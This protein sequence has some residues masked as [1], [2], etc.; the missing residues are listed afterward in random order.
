MNLK[1]AALCTAFALALSSP[2]FGQQ[3]GGDFG[4]WREGV[5]AEAAA[6]GVGQRG[7]SA[8][9]RAEL[10]Q[11]VIN[12]DRGQRVFTQTFAEFAGRMIN[13]YRLTHGKRNLERYRQT[14]ARAE[15]EFG[16]P[17]PVISS[18]WALETDFGAVQGDFSTLDALTTLA[19]DCRRPELFRPEL[20]ALLRLIDQGTVSADVTGAWAGEIGQL[21]MLPSDYLR[22][23][24][25]GDGD[26]RVDLKGSAPDAILT[27][28]NKLRALGWKPGQPWMDEVEVPEN[29]PWDQTGRVSKLPRAQWAAW[30]VRLRG[31]SALPADE[32]PAALVLPMGYK[33]PA[34]L[35]YDNYDTYL[36]WNKSLVYTLT[37]AQL[38]RRLDGAPPFRRGNPDPG[39]SPEQ[40][41]QLQRKL[42]EMGY[43]VG[44]VDGILGLNTR[45]AVRQIQLKLGLPADGWPTPSLLAQL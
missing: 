25:D 43:D 40:M 45:M 38:A 35:V 19:F 2:A 7:L 33:G 37:A 39:L 26:G 14:F 28:A 9:D 15:S 16:V 24:V 29:L 10:S 6:E 36:Q 27:A 5:K 4:A 18:F 32:L 1:R 31:G 42:L 41:K 3:C 20:I 30:G 12:M 17:A 34:F 21:Q 23:G 11:R 44:S 22:L 13:D 8:L